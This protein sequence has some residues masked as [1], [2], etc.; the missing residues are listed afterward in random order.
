MELIDSQFNEFLIEL[1]KEVKIFCLECHA[2]RLI[3]PFG[4]FLGGSVFLCSRKSIRRNQ[5]LQSLT[6]L[7]LLE[8]EI[9]LNHQKSQSEQ[10]TFDWVSKTDL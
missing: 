8:I 3:L 1:G 7:T 5:K 6:R 9:I 4:V 10:I 2:D